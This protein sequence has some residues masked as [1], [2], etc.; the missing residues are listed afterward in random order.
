MTPEEFKMM[1]QDPIPNPDETENPPGNPGGSP[2]G[3]VVSAMLGF[4]Q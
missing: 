2:G 4:A 3:F 1:G